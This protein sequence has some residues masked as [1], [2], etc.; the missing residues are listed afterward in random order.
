MGRKVTTRLMRL[1]PTYLPPSIKKVRNA[2]QRAVN[3]YNDIR[4]DV[5]EFYNVSII[6]EG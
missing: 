1:D 2:V 3:L 6:R 4:T 5:M